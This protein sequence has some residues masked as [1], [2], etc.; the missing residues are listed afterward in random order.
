LSRFH[1]LEKDEMTHRKRVR[2]THIGDM[3][4]GDRTGHYLKTNRFPLRERNR[5]EIVID[6]FEPEPV[7][8]PLPT[9]NVRLSLSATYK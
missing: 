2:A 7:I 4:P 8:H 5:S 3:S 6:R 9:R 1:S